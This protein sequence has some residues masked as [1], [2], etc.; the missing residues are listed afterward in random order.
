[1]YKIYHNMHCV[2]KS[3]GFHPSHQLQMLIPKGVLL[4]KKKH[5]CTHRNS[6]E[7]ITNIIHPHI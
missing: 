4:Q 3:Q 6:M 1:M 5:T 2:K 7:N